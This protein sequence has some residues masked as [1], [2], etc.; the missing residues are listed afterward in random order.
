MGILSLAVS[1]RP[2]AQ[3]TGLFFVER[4]MRIGMLSGG[5]ALCAMLTVA[6]ATPAA[7]QDIKFEHVMTFG[8]EGTGEGQFK[9]V[10]DF[11][12]SKD[13]HLLI[14]DAV[15][16]WVQV[17]DKAT[18]RFITRFGGKGDEDEHLEKP[19][20]IAVDPDGNVFIADYN[21]GYIKKYDRSYKWLLTFSE[22]GSEK[23]QNIK[24]ELMD[25]RDGKLYVPETGNHR[26]DVFD[27]YGKFLFDFGGMGSAPGK[28]TNPEAAKFASDG[29]VYVADLRN[30][31]VQVFD[32]DGKFIKAW[33][34]SGSSQGKFKSPAG[35]ALDKDDNVYVTEIGNN[36]VQVFDKEGNFLATWG[37]KGSGVGEFGNLHGIIVDKQTG[38]IY[39]GDTANNRVQVF[40]A[41]GTPTLRADIRSARR[42]IALMP[43][44]LR[45]G[46]PR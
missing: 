13:G 6:M 17:F 8:S 30:D 28:M 35:I 1:I 7:T 27:L 43:N 29:R 32:K 33:G 44:R 41:V 3:P 31:R 25:I 39:V 2:E 14:T 5:A 40:K 18:G 20:G 16:A 45:A 11:A 26:V 38:L 12:F 24:S 36:R 15:H 42:D 23:G 10:E 9:Y 4:L 21:S 34:K 46:P 37:K 19:E 22:Y